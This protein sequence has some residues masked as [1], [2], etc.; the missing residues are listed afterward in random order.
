MW[1]RDLI[2]LK[3]G[4]ARAGAGCGLRGCSRVEVARAGDRANRLVVVGRP[5]EPYVFVRCRVRGAVVGLSYPVVL[6]LPWFVYPIT[7]LRV[8]AGG[9]V[10][11]LPELV[12]LVSA[13]LDPLLLCILLLSFCLL[14]S[15]FLLLLR[16]PLS[17]LCS[18]LSLHVPILSRFRFFSLSCGCGDDGPLDL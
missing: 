5:V 1:S 12:Y 14:F 2:D 10:L 16:S 3:A 7:Y 17:V 15:C 8:A 13:L 9:F 6:T 11:E 18:P 4:R